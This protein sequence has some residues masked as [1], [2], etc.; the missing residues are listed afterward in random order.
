[1]LV[2]HA[3]SE[4]FVDAKLNPEA[5][6]S[7]VIATLSGLFMVPATNAASDRV[8]QALRQLEGFLGLS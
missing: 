4:G 5:T 7:L 1:V 6:A 3:Q 2:R 8:D